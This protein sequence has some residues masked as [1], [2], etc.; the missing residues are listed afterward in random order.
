MIDTCS[1][2][3]FCVVAHAQTVSF[4]NNQV[5]LELSIFFSLRTSLILAK[6]I[7]FAEGTS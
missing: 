6:L 5:S 1:V 4:L 7:T 2:K 3:Y